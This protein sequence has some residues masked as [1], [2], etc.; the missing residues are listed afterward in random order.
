MAHAEPTGSGEQAR[1]RRG[2][3]Y[4]KVWVDALTN[5]ITGTG[6]PDKDA[7]RASFWPAKLVWLRRT[8]PRLF[9]K[10]RRWMSPA[11]W[12]QLDLAGATTCAIGMATGTGL[13][14]PTKLHWD[15]PLQDHPGSSESD[16][17]LPDADRRL[18]C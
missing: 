16:R 9:A 1:D 5:Y 3:Y 14:N 17:R 2:L 4:G 15:D 18:T 10:V 11:E 7:P 8:Q 12:L 6:F 13:L